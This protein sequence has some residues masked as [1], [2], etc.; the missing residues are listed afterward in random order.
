MSYWP[1]LQNVK[2]IKNKHTK[3][4]SAPQTNNTSK[5]KGGYLEKQSKM[6][7]IR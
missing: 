4:T 2:L 3:H 5:G 6:G 1:S 7:G